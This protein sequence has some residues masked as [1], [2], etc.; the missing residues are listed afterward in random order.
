MAKWN[1]ARY[2]TR[3]RRDTVR[4]VVVWLKCMRQEGKLVHP[5]GTEITG[6]VLNHQP[7]KEC[8]PWS[9]VHV[10]VCG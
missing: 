1:P 10:E 5:A 6:S 3:R 2:A 8:S 9:Y 7:R 4:S